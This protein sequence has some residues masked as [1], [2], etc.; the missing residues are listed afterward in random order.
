MCKRG[1]NSRRSSCRE[2]GEVVGVEKECLV[3]SRIALR[4]PKVG[5][6]GMVVVG[7]V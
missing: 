2:E 4:E 7:V 5:G 3:S 6:N 1:V